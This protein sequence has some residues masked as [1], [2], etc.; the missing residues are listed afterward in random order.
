MNCPAC[1]RALRKK[2]I[3]GIEVEECE[4][5]EGIWFKAAELKQ[6]KDKTDS[7]LNWMD[8]DI[9]K[10]PEK[11]QATSERY[12]CPGCGDPMKV[13]EYDTTKV[14]I[15]YCEHCRSLWLDKDELQK[16]IEAL[17]EEIL[18]KSASSYVRA[19]LEEAKELVSGSE[20]FL[21]EWKDFTTI[22]RFLQYRILSLRP[23]IHDTIVYFQNNPL[24]R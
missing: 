2:S 6:I 12:D 21:S 15:D 24:N 11:F 9:W 22:L 18:T 8:F 4:S 17:E 19:T 3:Q 1:K 13:L 20:A 16:I 10:H 5:C 23:K 14:E 7:D